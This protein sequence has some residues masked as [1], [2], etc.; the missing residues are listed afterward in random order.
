VC[1]LIFCLPNFLKCEYAVPIGYVKP[2]LPGLLFLT[3]L[4]HLNKLT[5][6]L[7]QDRYTYTSINATVLGGNMTQALVLIHQRSHG[8][9][10]HVAAFMLEE[11]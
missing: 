5:E 7:G 3:K 11:H 4:I 6:L 8:D 9:Q 10:V 2:L 1:G